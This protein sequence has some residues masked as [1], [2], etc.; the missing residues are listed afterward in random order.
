M[1]FAV[2]RTQ[3]SHVL[4]INV[5]TPDDVS[6][7]LLSYSR[8]WNIPIIVESLIDYGFSDIHVVDNWQGDDL[9]S[10][11]FTDEDR[12]SINLIKTTMNSKTAGRTLPY[13]L[14]DNDVIATVDDDYVVT[15]DGWDQLLNAWTGDEIVVQLPDCNRKFTQAYK[16][17]FVDIGYGSLFHRD[18]PVQVYTM[19]RN[20]DFVTQEDQ[21]RF[22]DRI[23]TT[24]FGRWKAV[25]ADDYT[26]TRL[27]NPNGE[28]SESDASSIHLK[29]DYWRD[30]WALVA[31]VITARE[32][33]RAMMFQGDPILSE[34]QGQ[35]GFLSHAAYSGSHQGNG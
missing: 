30:Q 27:T 2:Y 4:D 24:F 3:L 15:E 22:A 25:E 10:T 33:I 6:V 19:L 9:L 8:P 14:F 11:M 35:M 1:G 7:V 32:K 23:F 26:L 17:P 16:T 12:E 31:K 13:D 5:I 18:W 34:Y 28:P 21:L 29:E 20:L